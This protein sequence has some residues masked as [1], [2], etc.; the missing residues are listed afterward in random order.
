MALPVA[1]YVEPCDPSWSSKTS[2]S[3]TRHLKGPLRWLAV[4]RVINVDNNGLEP[5]AVL[6]VDID[7]KGDRNVPVLGVLRGLLVEA[8]FPVVINYY[9]G[10]S[11]AVA[12]VDGTGRWRGPPTLRA[13]LLKLV[14]GSK[15]RVV[16]TVDSN[17]LSAGP[18]LIRGAV[19]VAL[20]LPSKQPDSAR[21]HMAPIMSFI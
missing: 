20:P 12:V 19:V 1:I 11:V 8:I 4:H 21:A 18:T 14:R 10:I 15:Q 3:P 7:R 13:T 6:V 16:L 5:V 2:T 17:G 9:V